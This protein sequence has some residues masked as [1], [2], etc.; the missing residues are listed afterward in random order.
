MLAA[1][2]AVPDLLTSAGAATFAL[3]AARISGLILIAPVFSSKSVPMQL[4]TAALI[5]F[6]VV[7]VPVARAHAH[8]APII[9]PLTILSEAIVGFGLG[10]GTAIVFGAAT[11]A[12]DLMS[13]QMGLAGASVLDPM[14]NI[15]VP[16]L[17]QFMSAFVIL[18]LFSS[19][20]HLLMIDS[21]GQS[22]DVIPVGT[23]PDVA[24]GMLAMSKMGG[25]LISLGVLFS[26]PVMAAT[27]LTNV[28]L[29]I[30][31]RAAPQLQIITVAFPL[32]IVAGLFTLAAAVSVTS[33]WFTGWASY[34]DG[35]L[36][37]VMG[38]MLEGMR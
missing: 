12:G 8:S 35:L 28:S 16:V 11:A 23:V 20:G 7:L 1:P 25:Q 32:Q 3:L 19:G 17:G 10:L 34:H 33:V 2:A 15:Q 6:T 26:A 5:I 38:P 36:S 37:R 4:R 13:V 21:L 29:A 24:A 27:M 18:L 14:T 31:T 30:L 22:L 9:T